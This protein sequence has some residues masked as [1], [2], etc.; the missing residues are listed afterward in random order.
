MSSGESE[1][2]GT[3]ED[4]PTAPELNGAADLTLH[5]LQS[6]A[7]YLAQLAVTFD[8]NNDLEAA[9]YYY[10]ETW[11]VLNKCLS[12]TGQSSPTA[13]DMEAKRLEYMTRAQ[14]LMDRLMKNESNRGNQSVNS[15]ETSQL[16]RAECLLREA[17]DEDQEG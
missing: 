14:T 15:G 9:V 4:E 3:H 8:T 7:Q 6:V 2:F 12:I 13:P 11:D 1:P 10:R 16:L 17:L 5:E